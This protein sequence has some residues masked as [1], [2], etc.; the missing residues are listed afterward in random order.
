M[1][2]QWLGRSKSSLPFLFSSISHLPSDLAFFSSFHFMEP[3][4][5]TQVSFILYYLLHKSFR[6]HV[7]NFKVGK[8]NIC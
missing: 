1:E 5:R 4:E 8:L 6:I 3:P 2:G 7:I